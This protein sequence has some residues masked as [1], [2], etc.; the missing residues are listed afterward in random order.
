MQ[1]YY[2]ELS[3]AQNNVGIGTNT[4]DASAKIDITSSNK[5]LLIPRIAL[6]STTDATTI[7]SPATSLLIYNTATAG[8]SPNNVTPGFYYNSSTPASPTWTRLNASN[9]SDTLGW[10][11]ALSTATKA[12]KTDN[13]YVTGKIGVGDFSSTTPAANLQVIGTTIIGSNTNTAT[14]INSF[15]SGAGTNA[16]GSR[17]F[18]TGENN[19]NAAD[20]SIVAGYASRIESGYG[21]SIAVGYT[22]TLVA[23]ASAAFGFGNKVTGFTGFAAGDRN[24]VTGQTATSFGYQNNATGTNSFS[25]G[26]SNNATGNLSFVNGINNTAAS[27]VET[28]LGLN[29]T[30]YTPSSTNTY[31]A[32]DRLLNVGNGSSSGSRSDAFTILKNGNIGINNNTPNSSSILD[33]NSSSKGIRLPNVA[34]TST[35]DASTITTPVTSLL[36]YNTA[37]AGVSPNNVT[38]GF[39]YNSNT[40]ASPIWTRLNTNTI[41]DTLGWTKALTTTTKA[42]KA[43]NQYVTGNIGVGNFSSISP[44][45]KIHVKGNLRIDSG[46]ID[47]RNTGQS[48]FV[49]EGAGI[50]DDLAARSNVAIGYNTLNQN[51]TGNNN[52]AIGTGALEKNTA[53]LNTAVGRFALNNLTTGFTNAAFGESAL[54]ASTTGFD[55]TA[56]GQNSL[57]FNSTGNRNTAVGNGAGYSNTGTENIFLGYQAGYNETG[58][59]KLYIENSSSATPLIYGDFST[60]QININGSQGINTLP[61]VSAVLDISSTNKGIRLPN[62][63]LTSTTDAATIATPAT[64]LLIYNTATAGVSPNNV[65]PGYY[66]N[67]NTPGSPI[68]T[69]LNTITIADTLGWTKALTTNT[70]AT[71]ADNQYVTGNVGIGDFSVSNPSDKL[72]VKGN[73]KVDAGRIPFVN[74]GQSVFIGENAGMSDDLTNNIN[75]F[76]G[77]DA[78]LSNTNGEANTFVGILS[79]RSNT[80]GNLNTAFGAAALDN[81]TIGASN[82]AVG[83][84]ALSANSTGN[85]NVA[86]GE[87]ALHDKTLGSDNVVIGFQALTSA[88]N[89]ANNVAVGKQAGYSN[90]NG[91]GNIFLGY[92]AG[93]NE[94]G[95]DK[96]YIDNS[97]TATPLIYGDFASNHITINDS[98]T[99]KYFQMTNGAANG[100]VLR[101]D[102]T[103]N[104]TWTNPATLITDTSSWT[105]A[106]TTNT[107]ANK[108]DN[109]YVTG[110]VGIGDFSAST[111]NANIQVIGNGNIGAGNTISGSNA[112]VTGNGNT[113]SG[114]YSIASGQFNNNAAE[115]SIIAGYFSRIENGYGHSILVGYTDTIAASS[116]AVFGVGNK[117]TAY[118]GFAAGD[119]N[120]VSG[121]TA[122]AFGGSNNATASN[123]FVTGGRN[124]VSASNAFATGNNNIANGNNSF[125][126]GSDNTASSFS[127]TTIGLY[128]TNYTPNS[129]TIYNATD[130]VLN[131]GNGVNSSARSDA[132]TILK[133][134]NIG[135]NNST[136]N[137][138]AILDIT[139]TNKGVRLPNVALTSTT[140]ATTIATP[141][142]S[143][144]I[145]N[146]AT[147][148]ISPNN[149]TPGFYY[150]S[151]TSV[152]PIWTRL[153]TNNTEDTLGWTK[154]LTST[155]KATKSDNQYVTGNIGVGDFSSAA[156]NDKIHVKGNLRID[157]GRIDFR[158]TGQS[159]FVGEG[160]G[161]ND[162]LAARSNVAIGYNSLN[163]NTTGNNNVAIGTGA[164]EKNTASFNTAVGRY[165]LKNVT[166]GFTNAA[167]GESTLRSSTT[168]FENTAFGQASLRFNITGNRNT[169]VGSA[170]G[171]NNTG[172]ANIFFGYQAGF[173]ETGNNKLYIENSSSAT[174][175]IYGDFASNHITINDSLTS[176]YF[177]M[178]NGAANGFVLRSDATG[179]ATWTNPATLITD[180]SSWTK[181]LT[182]N[183]TANKSDNQYVT[184]KVGIGDFSA[185]TPNANIQVI[186]NGNIGTG[187]TISGTNSFV[188]GFNNTVTGTQAF[189]TGGGNNV[190]GNYSV[191]LNNTNTTTSSATTSIVGGYQSY[192]SSNIG[193]AIGYNDTTTAQAAAAFGFDNNAAGANSFAA[194]GASNIAS[195]ANSLATGSN[196]S[197]TATQAFAAGGNNNAAGV[198]SFVAGGTN[199]NVSGNNSFVTGFNNT[200]TGTQAFAAG[201]GNNVAGNYSVALNNTNTTTNTATTSLVGGYQSYVT[202]NIGL[203][204][205]QNDTTTG[206][207][208]AAFGFDNNAAGVNSFVA[209]TD[210]LAAS[211]S[212]TALGING[213]RYTPASATTYNAT[214]R[215]FNVGNGAS[216]SNRADAF[217]ILKNGN[218]GVN[219]NTP[220]SSAILDISSINKGV[221]LPNVPLTSAVDAA[222]ITAPA[223]SLLIYNTEFDGV[224]PNNV[225]PGYY[226]NS[227]TPASP[228]WSRFVTSTDSIGW[229]KALS[230]STKA[231]KTDNQYV[232]GNIGIGDFS[233]ITPSNNISFT[234]GANKT[235]GAERSTTAGTYYNLTVQAGGAM[236]GQ[237]NN[238]GGDLILSGG[239][240]TGNGGSVSDLG[241]NVIFKTA[242]PLGSSSNADQIPTEKV[243]IKGDGTVN[244]ATMAGTGNRTVIVDAN[245]NLSA[246]KNMVYVEDRAERTTDATNSGFRSIGSSTGNL[247]VNTG[248]VIAIS[249]T[250]KFKWTGGTGTDQARFGINI[251]GCTSATVTDTYEKEDADD[252]NR[253]QYQ[254]FS[255]QYI[256]TATCNG[257]LQFNLLMDSNSNADDNAKTGDVVIVARKL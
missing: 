41:A 49:G 256:Y 130:R 58:N 40:S 117:V 115:N 206:Q 93:Y 209:G 156:P 84:S 116:A 109:Q 12:T 51:S 17:T 55:N 166:T 186:G 132:F 5:G 81:N 95:S 226:Y 236:A 59:N 1:L 80:T 144:L 193:L 176:K 20:N 251:T 134:G 13:Q 253:N 4:P 171:Y 239:T 35:T 71:I 135:V 103:G 160:A 100:F 19:L 105:K 143:L 29:G 126:N 249:L 114:N 121:Q 231:I 43:D 243:R 212:E 227:G 61:N 141:A 9:Y 252:V 187:N 70:K 64:S 235:I 25:I 87:S 111:P 192:V 38:P 191:A 244:V 119:K 150:N 173:N 189:S 241:S 152:S 229:I 140:D 195:G 155:T 18:V 175:L 240:A 233:A 2:A 76:V 60:N 26:Q 238:H 6:I 246:S 11:K 211:Y 10:T 181:A 44:S 73:I 62:I 47:F 224:A 165:A 27:Y 221:R 82:V 247:A 15:A 96:L 190:S 74:T 57:R 48:V 22:D 146:T 254:P 16:S 183:T 167:F 136:P 182:T 94:T 108:S 137:S 154:A 113:L 122:A 223:L 225:V 179:N 218:I 45:D 99:S 188:T 145:Y 163:Q 170:A 177:Q 101:S 68:W 147:A 161:I 90:L 228:K 157:S 220:N 202:S 214:D 153:N 205:G 66:Y 222:T 63:A 158:N 69:R 104:A 91:N 207:A 32:N 67:S 124:T 142:T 46:R 149:I 138:S 88:T 199:N 200:V 232:T 7:P 97:N 178:T 54:R 92:T 125:V 203:A 86:I 162:D 36:I 21:H 250:L 98:L 216:A 53:S 127:E 128:G 14:G 172:S 237:N 30:T 107:T 201:G 159:V 217:T 139:A 72:H 242:T 169:V 248:D 197:V 196:N 123:A 120:K 164:L 129:T 230:S 85:N 77:K 234:Q 208:A 210:N 83:R 75:V 31:N 257:N 174:P 89:V 23:S 148:G 56:L 52:V 180:T 184:G 28:V 198:N 65:T 110:K 106:L 131:V 8:V 50:N 151:N 79:G 168:G 213:T 112:L 78:G 39:Y 3:P 245:G 219:N 102:A 34:L 24:K 37:I 255:A 33:I 215:I 118:E 194:G 185:S 204:I 133:N 42:T